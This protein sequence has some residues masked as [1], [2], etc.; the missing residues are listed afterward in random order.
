MPAT[1]LSISQNVSVVDGSILNLTCLPF[2][3]PSPSIHWVKNGMLVMR[4]AEL[5][6]KNKTLII[7]NVA[8]EDEGLF[9]CVAVNRAG[10]DTSGVYVEVRGL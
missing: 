5:Y 8:V 1:V 2:G 4:N 9:T 10:N 7:R 3:D 6:E